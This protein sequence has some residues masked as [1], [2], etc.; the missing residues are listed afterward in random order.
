MKTAITVRIDPDLLSAARGRAKEENRTLTNYIETV[1]K[2]DLNG[3]YIGAQ[4]THRK[5]RA[6]SKRGSNARA[7]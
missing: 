2:R 1:L 5:M 7:A 4:P 3:A 6:V